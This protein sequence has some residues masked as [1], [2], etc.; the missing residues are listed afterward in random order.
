MMK[1]LFLHE[2]R[3]SLRYFVWLA[4]AG[5]LL[6][7][8]ARLKLFS[9][10]DMPLFALLFYGAC[11]IMLYR[12]WRTMFGGE[13]TFCFGAPMSAGCQ[14]AARLLVFAALSV[15][16]TALLA[17]SILLQGEEMG[18]LLAALPAGQAATLFLWVALSAL[19]LVVS[20]AFAFTLGNLPVFRA[21]R[22]LCCGLFAAAMLA[23]NPLLLRVF[24]FLPDREMIIAGSEPAEALG[25]HFANF[26]F[27]IRTLVIELLEAPVFIGLMAMLT[28]KYMLL[29]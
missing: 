10:T 24:A 1:N 7:L 9:I 22:L 3:Q 25:A 2:M 20:Y 5:L 23:L 28:R 15:C 13:A 17:A 6:G 8:L 21:H 14:I 27:S 16:G 12:F 19:L 4:G 29:E 11:G 26:S 18:R